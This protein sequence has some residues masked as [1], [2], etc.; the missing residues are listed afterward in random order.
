MSTPIETNTEELRGVLNDV[1]N[2][3]NRSTGGSSEPDLV[4]EFI[5]VDPERRG[6]NN[7]P[8]YFSYDA[9]D[10]I[11]RVVE[12]LRA[13]KPVNCI[14]NSYR[15]AWLDEEPVL[16]N[17]FSPLISAHVY[18]ENTGLDGYVYL[19]LNF[20][21]PYGRD[22]IY[23]PSVPVKIGFEIFDYNTDRPDIYINP[24]CQFEE[25]GEGESET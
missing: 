13:K 15:D 2:L 8:E 9:N 22:G 19:E 4:I 6:M 12:K 10:A 23:Y 17:M 21:L 25:Q 20:S 1:Y 16:G 18:C 5:D 24:W 7:H 3:P 11:I 14:L